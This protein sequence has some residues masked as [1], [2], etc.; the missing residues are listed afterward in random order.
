MKSFTESGVLFPDDWEN[1]PEEPAVPPPAPEPK[2]ERKVRDTAARPAPK[3]ASED[4]DLDY[5][6]P[7]FKRADLVDL[8]CEEH[9]FD[10]AESRAFVAEFFDMIFDHLVQGHMV[11]LSGLGRF[12]VR[13]KAPRPARN[14]WTG[15]TVMLEERTVVCY[16]SSTLSTLASLRSFVRRRRAENACKK[17]GLS[18]K[19]GI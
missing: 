13:Y 6:T 4:E 9:G 18:R 11:K 14:P 10:V 5:G 7:C 1:E 17:A 15:E 3:L 12:S 8:L 19:Y 2:P 16:Q